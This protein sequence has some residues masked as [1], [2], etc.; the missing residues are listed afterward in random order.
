MVAPL[1]VLLWLVMMTL[2]VVVT[3]R[4]VHVQ[5]GIFGPRI[6]VETIEGARVVRPPF[7]T[8]WGIRFVARGITYSVPGER[9]RA[10]GARGDSE[11]PRA[12][13]AVMVLRPRVDNSPSATS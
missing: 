9:S 3:E 4:R 7:V 10:R 2:R 6:P 13:S 11:E 12:A 1:M 8:G 5:L